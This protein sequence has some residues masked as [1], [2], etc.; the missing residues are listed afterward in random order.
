[1]GLVAYHLVAMLSCDDN[2][3]VDNCTSLETAV[4]R[5]NGETKILSKK[6]KS[7]GNLA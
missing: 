7:S 3:D 1:M 6:P 2:R 5:P 4:G